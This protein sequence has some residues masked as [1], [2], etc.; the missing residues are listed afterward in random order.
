M[1]V[2]V[3]ILKAKD[4]MDR[5]PTQ[6]PSLRDLDNQFAGWLLRL[7]LRDALLWSLRG[8]AAGLAVALVLSLV[9][10]LRPF[11]PVPV[12]IGLS[13]ALALTGLGLSLALAFFWPRGKLASAR[14]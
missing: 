7:R 2:L 12:L 8:L 1:I 14:Y 4:G 9:A 6:D 11:Q 13:R 3:R 10:W 5:M